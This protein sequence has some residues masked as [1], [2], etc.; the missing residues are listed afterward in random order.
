MIEKKALFNRGIFS[1]ILVFAV[2]FIG[3]SYAQEKKKITVDK[4]A[5]EKVVPSFSSTLKRLIRKAERNINKRNRKIEQ[6]RNAQ[7]KKKKQKDRTE[8]DKK[9]NSA[10]K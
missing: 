3:I 5:V 4:E 1:A 2:L 6:D 8:E 7:E 10:A 9:E